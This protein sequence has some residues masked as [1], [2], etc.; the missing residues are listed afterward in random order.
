MKTIFRFIAPMAL[1]ALALSACQRESVKNQEIEG[2]QIIRVHAT[3]QDLANEDTRTYIDTY[4]DTPNT[5]L[6]GTGEYMKLCV[7]SVADGTTE[8]KWA[9]STDDSADLYDGEPEALFEFSVSPQD[10]PSYLYQGLYPASAAVNSNNDNPAN[11]K[12]NLIATQNATASSYDPAAYI[13]VAKPETFY[14]VETDWEAS[15]RRATALNKITLKNVPAG[16]SIKRVTITVPSEKY[17]AGARH[18]DLSTGESGDI[19]NGGGRTETVEVKYET[20][21]AG[22]ANMDVWF[23]SWDVE[24]EAGETLTIVAFTTD[25]KSY[26]KTITV[27]E[28]KSIKFQ[29]G[30]LNKLTANMSG[31]DPQNVTELEEGNY[32]ILAKDGTVY[33]ALKAE[34][35]GSNA[36]KIASVVYEGSLESY[37]GDADMVWT[38]S[39]SDGSYIIANGSDYVGWSSGNTAEFKAAG[40]SWTT[41]NY[42]IDITWNSANNCYYAT[43]KSDSTRKLQKNSST[44]YFAFYTS[45]Q[46]DQ[47]IFVPATVDTRAELVLS[48]ENP[49]ITLTTD[50][51]VDF[52]GQYATAYS[53]GHEVTG[54]EITYS[55]DI[56]EEDSDF[57]AIDEN[58][59]ICLGGEVGVTATVTATFEGNETYRP[60]TAT[61]T[62]TVTENASPDVLALSFPFTSS[63]DGWP[64]SSSASAAGSYTYPLSGTNYTFT[65]TKVGNGIY[66][67]GSYLMIVAGNYLGLP[68]IDGYKLTKVSA[69]LNAG[70]NPSTASKGKITSDTA[71]TVVTGG[72][73]QTFDTKGGVKTFTLTGTEENTVYYLAISNKNFQCIGIDLEYEL[74]APDTREEAGMSW[75]DDAASA[76]ITTGQNG[77]VIVF[78][79]PTLDEGNAYDITFESTV[80][81]VAT[82]NAEGVVNIVGPGETVIKAIF[83]GDEDYKPQTVSYDLTVTD[84]RETVATPVIDPASG[85]VASG[86]QVT[87]TCETSGAAIH[88][89]L[90]GSAPTAESTTYTDPITL[91]ATKTI[92]AIAVKAGYKDS[93]VA[94][95]NLTVGVTNTSTEENPYSAAEAVDLAG[96]L[97]ANGTL[98]GVYVSGIISDITQAYSTNYGNVTFN[99]S[100]DGL[101][102]STQFLIFRM[103]A[104]SA[105]DFKVGDAVEIKGTLKNYKGSSQTT[106]TPELTAD[107]TLIY[108]Y[109][110]PTFNPNGASFDN[111]QSVTISAEDGA[112]IRYTVNGDIPTATTGTEYSG[113]FT[114]TETTTVKALAIKNGIATGVV[115]AIFT[116]NN[117]GDGP[118]PVTLTFDVSSNPGEWPTANSTTLTNY[119]YTLNSVA[120]TFALKNVKCNSGY[121]MLTQTAALGLP[122]IEGYKLTKVVAHNSSTCSTSTKVGISSS[123]SSASYIDGGAIQTWSTTGS[124]YTY[125]LTSTEEETVYYLYVT[126]KNAQI[127]S[128]DLTYTPTN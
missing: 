10:A 98:D 72:E 27:P 38:V 87:I 3:A 34:T 29:E 36:D 42:L 66:C 55:W 77:A 40:D 56:P 51:Y 23:T 60:A 91:T 107:F 106:T 103:P 46:K 128:L 11:Y 112:T 52:E 99:I 15:Y 113:A 75:S 58:G 115:S 18:I 114:L 61:Y 22:G 25:K 8:N 92:K 13:M 20:P 83:A 90:D 5:I 41:T 79:A 119:T 126:N 45:T 85:T 94:T 110:A 54:L 117:G 76:S 67:A 31:I 127:V 49:T 1:A 47:L 19:Y 70:G 74:V 123:A 57:G 122:A 17:L 73:E 37:T 108:K 100:A 14:E 93:A 82:V 32:L 50:N 24:V 68:A 116:K 95:A 39:K 6:W 96:Q 71:G 84:A 65:H 16:V 78:A 7:T 12:V 102:T 124:S 33:H 109:H 21:L 9:N 101:T 69:Q 105:D 63:I 80:P 43:L 118:Q 121:L 2:S 111:S 26:T 59:F 86:S 120:Y 44:A 28:N 62:I 97:A 88:Y 81:T 104:E 35:A 64:A 48:F 125:T 30:Y 4:N 53:D 89:T